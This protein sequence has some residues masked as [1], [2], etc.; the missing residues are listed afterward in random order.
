MNAVLLNKA[1][2]R[3]NAR[4]HAPD[5]HV[6]PAESS[7]SLRPIFHTKKVALFKVAVMPA[8]ITLID[9]QLHS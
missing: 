2:H 7:V 3:R 1:G 6:T 4:S 8:Q 9:S 5:G